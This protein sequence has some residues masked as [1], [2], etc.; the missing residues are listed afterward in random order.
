[1][2]PA[3]AVTAIALPLNTHP[4]VHNCFAL[5]VLADVTA[6]L[7]PVGPA[8][9][10]L[11]TVRD[12]C[13]RRVVGLGVRMRVRVGVRVGVTVRVRAK[14]RARV[15]ARVRVR[16]RER[17]RARVSEHASESESEGESE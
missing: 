8:H 17:M 4:P 2:L 16:V 15:G 1:M 10:T 13:V 12:L 5:A 6:G 11:A 3:I 9:C 7:A 14:V